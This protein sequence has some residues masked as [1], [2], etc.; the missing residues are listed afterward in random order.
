MRS[1]L[2]VEAL[3]AQRTCTPSERWDSEAPIGTGSEVSFLLAA[4]AFQRIAD[5][6]DALAR[7]AMNDFGQCVECGADI[8]YQRLRALPTATTCYACSKPARRAG[9]GEPGWLPEMSLS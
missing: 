5:I 1:S 7:I 8:P 2:V 9:G 4:A 6:D 3:E